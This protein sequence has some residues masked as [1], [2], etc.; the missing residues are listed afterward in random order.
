MRNVSQRL[1]CC[2]CGDDTDEADDYIVIELRA[3]DNDGRQFLGAHAN[4]ADRSVWWR[5][6]TVPNSKSTEG[7]M[8]SDAVAL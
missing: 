5:V 2:I 1:R 4:R 3:E 8:I 7:F 6:M